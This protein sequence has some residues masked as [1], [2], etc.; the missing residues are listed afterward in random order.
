M[1][2]RELTELG[3][4]LVLAFL[5]AKSKYCFTL[6]F[7]SSLVGGIYNFKYFSSTTPN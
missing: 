7:I 6:S 2:V 1:F 5:A 4:E 3:A